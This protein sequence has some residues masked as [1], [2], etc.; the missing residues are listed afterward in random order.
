[1]AKRNRTSFDKRRREM[2][3][4]KNRADKLAKKRSGE[5]I[6]RDIPDPLADFKEYEEANGVVPPAEEGS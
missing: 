2:H 3:K 5:P 1:M 4:K 6:E